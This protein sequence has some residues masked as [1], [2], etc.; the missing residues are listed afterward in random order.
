[1]HNFIRKTAIE[2]YG[3]DTKN[4]IKVAAVAR[5]IVNWFKGFGNPDFQQKLKELQEV[6]PEIKSLIDNLSINI[7]SL[8]KALS[9]TDPEG[10]GKALE[11]V[12]PLI[13]EL[14]TKLQ[15]MDDKASD[16]ISGAPVQAVVDEN[17]RMVQVDKVQKLETGWHKDKDNFN[18]L[19][20]FLPQSLDVP[21]SRNINKPMNSFS[22]FQQFSPQEI[23][24]SQNAQTW[25]MEAVLGAV[26]QFLF[27]ADVNAE[28]INSVFKHIKD[29]KHFIFNQL[30][31]NILSG[32]LMA[33]TFPSSGQPNKMHMVVNAGNV[34]IPG[35]DYVIQFP[36]VLLSDKFTTLMP[37]KELELNSV[38]HVRVQESTPVPQLEY[39]ED[40][41]RATLE[42]NNYNVS[43]SARELGISESALRR[44]MQSFNIVRPQNIKQEEVVANRFEQ[45]IKEAKEPE[46]LQ[47]QQFAYQNLG[48]IHGWARNVI[49]AAFQ[50]VMGRQPTEGEIQAT[51]AVAHLESYYGRG[52]K[53]EGQ[54]SNNWGAIQCVGTCN[55]SNSFEYKD[56]NPQQD[57]TQKWY[58]T[59]FRKYPT[60]EA[61]A[62]DLIKTLFLN[63]TKNYK[64]GDN[65]RT[66]GDLLLDAANNGDVGAFSTALY[67]TSYY[68]GTGKDKETRVQRHM[69]AMNKA[70]DSMSKATGNQIV[71]INKN[72]EQV[73]DPLGAQ[74]ADE[75]MQ[76]LYACGPLEKI[77]R[78][79][80]YEKKLPRTKLLITIANN[81]KF[82]NRVRFAKILAS[83]LRIDMQA[84]CSIH[85]YEDRIQI[86]ADISGS[87]TLVK[88]C[89]QAV[90]NAVS[91]AFA[92]GT[93]TKI[94][95]YVIPGAKSCYALINTSTMEDCFRKF[96][97]D[98]AAK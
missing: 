17:G 36:A 44:K 70:L 79:A 9:N 19:K 83:A 85:N 30:R 20:S 55:D 22:W 42:K 53:G 58:T 5:K 86:E 94:G 51:Q 37:V 12:K 27:D 81:D 28:Y 48:D 59:R 46:K 1:M 2:L 73:Q 92:L 90:C 93:G 91:D 52:W 15:D 33:Y 29:N 98:M 75:L 65:T 67:E 78:R 57:G 3:L 32:I 13:S 77:V 4:V 62:A 7:D 82:H 66:R 24:I 60:P 38:K 41:V 76:F 6:S 84:E 40:I 26:S 88:N 43:V 64:E 50:K 71:M 72:Q 80:L 63:K 96:A 69:Q 45:F 47:Y 16:V 54:G 49:I 56:S 21:I 11:Q 34:I 31:E 18:K 23:R 74:D 97:F 89:A 25:I 8:N 68:G 95:S 61:G 35:I 14:S 87:E 39:T 10:F